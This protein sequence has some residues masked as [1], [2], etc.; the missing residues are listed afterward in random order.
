MLDLLVL[1]IFLVDT[2]DILNLT[3]NMDI[4]HT[5]N[6]MHLLPASTCQV[7][8]D[9]AM[10]VQWVIMLQ[11]RIM[12]DPALKAIIR[13]PHMDL[14]RHQEVRHL[15]QVVQEGLHQAAQ[16]K[17]QVGQEVHQGDLQ[18]EHIQAKA[19]PL[20][21]QKSQKRRRQRRRNLVRRMLRKRLSMMTRSF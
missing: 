8:P 10:E 13:I 4:I 20:R 19:T 21:N 5:I 3:V 16:Y 15:Q 17:V 2:V 9:Q 1:I 6:N 14:V 7:R 12:V 11:I 18:E